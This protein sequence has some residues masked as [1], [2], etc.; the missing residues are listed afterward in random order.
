MKINTCVQYFGK[1]VM[2][3]D[4]VKKVKTAWKQKG[5]KVK[6]IENIDLYIKIE[7]NACYYVVNDVLSGMI[8]MIG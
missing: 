2:A 6:E 4:L 3:D 1:E 5:H 7:E 8:S